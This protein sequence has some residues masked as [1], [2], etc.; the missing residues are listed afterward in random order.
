MSIIQ[1]LKI[2]RHIKNQ[3]NVTHYQEKT[4]QEK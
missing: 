2:N 4:S 1:F 3:E